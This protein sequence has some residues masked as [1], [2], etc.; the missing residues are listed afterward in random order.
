MPLI[1]CQLC[2]RTFLESARWYRCDRCGFR[3]CPDCFGRH[4][5]QYGRLL[6]CSRCPSGQ[7]RLNPG[8]RGTTS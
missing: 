8:P 7:M 3:V 1:P 4:Q 6:K 5:G 2:G